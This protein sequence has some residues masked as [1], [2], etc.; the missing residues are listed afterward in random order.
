MYRY[1]H[2]IS[3]DVMFCSSNFHSCC[4]EESILILI[5]VEVV[6]VKFAT[7]DNHKALKQK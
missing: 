3:L 5:N 1:H 7:I 6:D 2:K 4:N